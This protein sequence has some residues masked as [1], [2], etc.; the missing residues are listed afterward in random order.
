MSFYIE[1]L[2]LSY[3]RC[4]LVN[5]R[6]CIFLVKIRRV[7]LAQQAWLPRRRDLLPLQRFPVNPREKRMALDLLRVPRPRAEPQRGVAHEQ[8]RNEVLR[9]GGEQIL[10]QNPIQIAPKTAASR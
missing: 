8:P 4:R 5:I 9:G 2:P 6:I 3:R 10:R 1:L 7:G